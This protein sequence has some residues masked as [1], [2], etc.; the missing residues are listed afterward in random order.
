MLD[1]L[2]CSG[3]TDLDLDLLLTGLLGLDAAL[4]AEAG[5]LDLVLLILGS[6][7]VLDLLLVGDIVP[8]LGDLELVLPPLLLDGVLDLLL[9]DLVN[10]APLGDLVTA[11]CLGWVLDLVLLLL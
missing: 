3:P 7:G 6:A 5:V 1:L 10:M 4:P 2:L 8:L 9:G 11:A